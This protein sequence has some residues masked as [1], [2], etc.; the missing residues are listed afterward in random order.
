MVEHEMTSYMLSEV[1]R[2]AVWV[3][4]K[5]LKIQ[6]QAHD[7]LLPMRRLLR[8]RTPMSMASRAFLSLSTRSIRLAVVTAVHLVLVTLT[9]APFFEPSLYAITKCYMLCYLLISGSMMG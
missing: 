4:L 3:S 1:S 2:G 5:S 7:V 6:T 8:P 9:S